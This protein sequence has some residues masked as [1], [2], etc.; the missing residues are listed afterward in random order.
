M[1][2]DWD[3]LAE[4]WTTLASFPEETRPT[5][6][7][8]KSHQDKKTRYED[9]PLPAQLNVDADALAEEYEV[10]H[11]NTNCSSVLLL[12]T[13]GVQLH[14][15]GETVT[16]NIKARLKTART[17]NALRDK[18]CSRFGWSLETHESIHHEA[19]RRAVNNKKKHETTLLKLQHGILPLGARLHHKYD[20]KYQHA[21][22]SCNAADETYLHMIRCPDR[23]AWRTTFLQALRKQMSDTNTPLDVIQLMLDGVQSVLDDKPPS[24]IVAPAH[25]HHILEAQTTIGWE[26]VLRGRLSLRWSAHQ[27]AHLSGPFDPL[28]NGATWTTGVILVVLTHFLIVW[29]KR[30]KELHGSDHVSRQDAKRK[31]CIREVEL[32][33]SKMDGLPP[34][35]AWILELPIETRLE[36]PGP[37]LRAWISSYKPIIE[38]HYSDEAFTVD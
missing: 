22:P 1:A 27:Q 29:T 37:V 31:Q 36:S 30:N 32:L 38:A 13:S 19:A 2:S 5:T 9:L 4:L 35:Y 17:Y 24:D 21:C 28:N 7:H 16:Y 26:H 12:P 11:P 18:Q 15:S 14:L 10:D 20:P 3:T 33:Y 6:T 8:V 34:E 25:L 23:Q